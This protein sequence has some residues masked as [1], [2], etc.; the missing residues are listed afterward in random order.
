MANRGSGRRSK[1]RRRANSGSFQPGPDPRRH[2]F[3][4]Q[5]CWLGYAVC[6]IKHPHLRHWLRRRVRCYYAQRE[7]QLAGCPF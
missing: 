4:R 2:V 6:Y 3:T 5:D 7:K 1:K